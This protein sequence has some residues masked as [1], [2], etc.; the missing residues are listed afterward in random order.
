MS[1]SELLL[2]QGIVFASALVY[3]AGVGVL[4]RRIRRHIGR[5]PNVKPRGAKERLLWAGWMLVTAGWLIQPLFVG[6]GVTVPWLRLASSLPHALTL[7]FGVLLVV[8]GHVGTL[9]CYAAMGDAWRMGIN[10]KEKNA[11]VKHGPYRTVRHP[12]YLFQIILLAGAT[13]LLPTIL[14][15]V[16]MGL[17]YVCVRIKALDEESYLLAAHGQPYRDY[18]NQTGRLLPPLRHRAGPPA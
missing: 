5:A 2:R 11:L 18:L 4:A 12:I 8:I 13:C 9:R 15:L 17:H 7:I 3:W 1:S 10:R 14:S 16:I 6:A